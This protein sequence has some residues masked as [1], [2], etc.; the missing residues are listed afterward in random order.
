MGFEKR[1]IKILVCVAALLLV[2][3]A[4]IGLVFGL[5]LP[6]RYVELE[7]WPRSDEYN[8]EQPLIQ[9]RV[10]DPGSWHPW[11]NRINDFLRAYETNVP[12]EPPRAPCS[13]LRHDQR[14]PSPNCE[15]ALSVWAP[16]IADNFYGY[17]D[18]TPCVFLRLSHIHYWVPEPY[19]VSLPLALPPDMPNNI[20]QIMMQRPAHV[21]GDYV[22]VSCGGEFSSDQENIGP[23]QYIPAGLPPGFPTSRLHTA[24]RIPHSARAQPDPLPGPL[25]ALLFENPR[26]GVLINVECRIWTRD[27]LYDR[28]RHI[29]RARFEIYVE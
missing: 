8:R 21:Y 5:I 7:V 17:R 2:I 28:S 12:E 18:G 11:Y 24:D 23:L 6:F 20:K 25:I 27:I 29:G 10:N 13:T 19:N 16:C 22:W 14:V 3:G 1:T 26:R 9:F 4:I 15:R